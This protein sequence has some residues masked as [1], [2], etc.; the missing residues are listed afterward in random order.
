MYPNITN[1]E[2]NTNT[3]VVFIHTKTMDKKIKG[4]W[5]DMT[6][7][8]AYFAFSNLVQFL[9]KSHSIANGDSIKYIIAF[10]MISSTFY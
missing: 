8:A 9:W 4:N 1:D 5:D 6:K 2:S 3:T 10:E 7:V